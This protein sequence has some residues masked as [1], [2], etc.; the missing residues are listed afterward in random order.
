MAKRKEIL[1]RLDPA[2][3]EALQSWAADE[4][5]S[6]NAQLELILRNELKKQGRLPQQISP[7]PR[8]GRPPKNTSK[9]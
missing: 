5:R 1:I 6:A 9:T 4:L 8:R 2:V 7:I 3:Y